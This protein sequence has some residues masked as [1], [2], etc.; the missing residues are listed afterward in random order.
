VL[1]DAGPLLSWLTWV[2][3]EAEEGDDGLVEG[4]RRLRGAVMVVAATALASKR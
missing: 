2:D 3:L 1:L 4:L